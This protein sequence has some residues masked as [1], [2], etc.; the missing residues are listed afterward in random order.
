MDA[1]LF[2]LLTTV[3]A[4][5]VSQVLKF[6]FHAG[7]PFDPWW[8]RTGGMPSS[9]TAPTAAA[10]TSI[11]L[12]EGFSVLFVFSLIFLIAIIRDAVGVRY[13]VGVNAQVLKQLLGKKK[14]SDI[15]VVQEGHTVK[16]VAAG[17]VIG[18]V[19]SVLLFVFV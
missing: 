6:F 4:W 5:V 9:H 3:I 7:T 19:V 16:Q 12:V 15:V 8:W 13:A 11:F 10:V 2:V 18:L 1:P 14:E 17:F